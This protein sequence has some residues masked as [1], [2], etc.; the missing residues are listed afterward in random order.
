MDMGIQNTTET[1]QDPETAMALLV[2]AAVLG[3]DVTLEA[4]EWKGQHQLVTSD[5]LPTDCNTA[6][7]EAAGFTF[8]EPVPGDP[9][10]RKATMPPGWTR[11]ASDH[12]MHSH[13]LDEHGR[14]R[15]SVF[16]KAAHYDRRARMSLIGVSWYVHTCVSRNIEPI[17]DEAWATPALIHAAATEN[18]V[19]FAEY[20]R[21]SRE[22]GDEK[23]AQ[24]EEATHEA[25][26]ALAERFAPAASGGAS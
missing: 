14:E 26:L 20:A 8:G 21:G 10:F 22:A 2:S 7:F 4:V 17:P 11:R 3:S 15:V 25:F 19:K 18:A 1:T 5:L 12:A 16:Y 6:A 23:E 9:L 24:K 13:I